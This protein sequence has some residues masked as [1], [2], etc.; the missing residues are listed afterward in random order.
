MQ[1]KTVEIS[2][3]RLAESISVDLERRYEVYLQTAR[4]LATILGDYEYYDQENR[5]TRFLQS[6]KSLLEATPH[7]VAI[8]TIWKPNVLDDMDAQFAGQAGSS[9]TGQFIPQYTRESGKIELYSYGKYQKVAIMAQEE[10]GEPEVRTINGQ[11]G[12]SFHFRVPIINGQHEVAGVVGVTANATSTQSIIQNILDNNQ[13]YT[14][15]AAVAVYTNAGFIIG[16]FDPKQIGKN[17]TEAETGLYGKFLP[18]ALSA[19]QTGKLLP[20]TAY[21]PTF[22]TNLRMALVPLVV[23]GITST[24]W[25][26][27][28][29]STEADILKDINAMILFAIIVVV[30]SVV[31]AAVLTFFVVSRIAKP[32]V[33]VSLTL[34]DIAEGEGDL[35]KT[36]NI[37][38]KD[39]IGDL[40]LYFNETLEKIRNLVITIKNQ[41]V[42]LF[43]IGSELASNMTETAAAI[44]EITA[45][46][47]SIKSRV[48]NQSASVTETNATME[49][50]TVNIDK[51]NDHIEYQSANVSQSSS[52]IEEMLASIQSLA[53][54]MVQ[55]AENV[56]ELADA[57]GVGRTGLQEVAADI[58]EIAKESEGLLEINAVMQNIASQTN[59]LSMNAAIEAAHAGDVGKGFAVVA[60]EIRKLAENSG[61][62]SKTISTV[63]K[64]IKDSIDKI[65]KSTDAVL[66]KFEAIDGGV[67]T[68]SEKQMY[69]CS[70]LEELNTGSKQILDTLGQLNGITVKVKSGSAEMLEGSKEVIHESKNLEMVTQELSNGMSEMAIGADQINIA[71]NRINTISGENKNNIDILVKEIAKFKVE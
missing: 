14:D 55:N 29:G 46:I 22:K 58:Q 34:K 35:T 57:S 13:K 45:T 23:G 36:I 4:N 18:Q 2:E 42:T 44:N 39:E 70:S 17:V 60:D 30:F 59:L 8:Y 66:N 25:S 62:Q 26:V 12:Y 32:I 19:I 27:M 49:Q 67:K 24:P 40:A 48:I 7:F 33:D 41:A 53:K 64:K 3:E 10:L 52:S 54:T 11:V 56:K 5:R 9:E 38:S 20:I 37:A 28:V 69:V 63:L 47:Q 51:L 50:I 6:M 21:S 65:M 31:I 68:V 61:A 16:H 1:L 15:V 71:V 43:D